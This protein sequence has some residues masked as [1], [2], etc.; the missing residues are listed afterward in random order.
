MSNSNYDTY[1]C[2]NA[3]VDA[4]CLAFAGGHWRYRSYAGAFNLNV[5]QYASTTYAHVG[6]RL[7]FL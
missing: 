4:S 1:Y 5:G 2:D 6:A 7:M 3:Y